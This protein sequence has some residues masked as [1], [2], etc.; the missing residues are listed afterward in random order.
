MKPSPSGGDEHRRP[1]TREVAVINKQGIHARPAALFVKTAAKFESEI[2]VKKENEVVNG[3]S[4]IGLLMLAAGQGT[5]LTLTADGRDAE[6]ALVELA[7]L[8]DEKFNE[9]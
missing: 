5:K 1:L 7:K 3:K 9:D 2:S 8:F 6:K 4:I